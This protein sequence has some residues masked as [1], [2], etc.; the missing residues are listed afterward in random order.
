MTPQDY[1]A[2]FEK[3]ARQLKQI[4]HSDTSKRFARIDIEEVLT[5]LRNKINLKEWCLVLES[6]EG[7]LQ[8]RGDEAMADT[9][10]GAFMVVR[11]VKDN[12]FAG[13]AATISESKAIGLKIIALLIR[14]KQLAVQ[15]ERPR[16]LRGFQLGNVN[17]QKVGPLFGENAYGY[18]FEFAILE[19]QH[20]I[21]DPEDWDESL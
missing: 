18:R 15:G 9:M 2:Y 6:Y 20:L 11:Q 8:S 7:N 12:D 3:V 19:N 21:Y 4:G 1:I 13:Q 16:F 5:G 10:M 17:Y 14:D